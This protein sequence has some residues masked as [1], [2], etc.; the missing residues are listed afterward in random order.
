MVMAIKKSGKQSEPISHTRLAYAPLLLMSVLTPMAHADLHE[1]VT[2]S[3]YQVTATPEDN[4]KTAVDAASPIR[5]NGAIFTG[6]TQNNT[7]WTFSYNT[8]PD[9]RCA[10]ESVHTNLDVTV[11]L[12]ELMVNDERQRA[13]FNAYKINLTRH[14]MG[15]VQIARQFAQKIDQTIMNLPA[16]STCDELE[17]TANARGNEIINTQNAENQRYDAVTQ[18]GQNQA[19]WRQSTHQAKTPQL[20]PRGSVLR[21]VQK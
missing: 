7:T 9:G 3:T 14:E 6:N 10:I 18:H 15:H 17:S 13:E 2:T 16:A 20:A 19:A 21:L 12:P 8:R 4:W 1:N 11:T 5:E